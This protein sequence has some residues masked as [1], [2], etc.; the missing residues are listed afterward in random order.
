M[1]YSAMALMFGIGFWLL[2]LF[3]IACLTIYTYIQ[4]MYMHMAREDWKRDIGLVD[5]EPFDKYIDGD[6]LGD[7]GYGNEKSVDNDEDL[8]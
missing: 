4:L 5:S 6:E 2:G 3:G 1:T 7:D 8:C